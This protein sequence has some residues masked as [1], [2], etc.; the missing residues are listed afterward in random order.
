MTRN[1]LSA[2][3]IAVVMLSMATGS[4]CSTAAG[5]QFGLWG[6]PIP[7]SP[8]MQKHQED[9]AWD[10]ERYERVPVLGPINANAPT[11]ALDP[12]TPDEVMRALERARGTERGV[13]LLHEVARNNVR[14]VVDPISDY[15]DPP[16]IFPL[17]GP[18]Q[19]HHA[20]YKCTVYFSETT[21]NGWPLPY[22]TTDEDASEVIYIDHTHFH[23]VADPG[24]VAAGGP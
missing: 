20:N 4:G 18:A 3:L 2:A 23:R 6:Y 17:I 19:I 7:V 15:L 24:S 9:K 10:H 12:P 22:T 5:P 1:T 8:Y 13:P 14:I 11:I 21:H 16:R